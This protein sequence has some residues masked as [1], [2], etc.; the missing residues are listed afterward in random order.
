MC[1]CDVEIALYIHFHFMLF[2]QIVFFII[3]FFKL[4]KLDIKRSKKLLCK[5]NN[6]IVFYAD[7]PENL[8]FDYYFLFNVLKINILNKSYLYGS[9]FSFYVLLC[10]YS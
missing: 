5:S 4:V 9:I 3:F 1:A 10:V 8:F 7:N 6:N 2:L